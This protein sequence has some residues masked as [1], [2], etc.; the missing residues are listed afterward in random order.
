MTPYLGT[1]DIDGTVAQSN[2]I[3]VCSVQ[4]RYRHGIRFVAIVVVEIECYLV[5]RV[6][7]GTDK[8]MNYCVCS[9]AVNS[10]LSNQSRQSITGSLRGFNQDST[11]VNTYCKSELALTRDLIPI[12]SIS[13]FFFISIVF[14]EMEI[15]AHPD[16]NIAD[17]IVSRGCH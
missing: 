13:L 12:N 8:G 4:H 10:K 1:L 2:Q 6:K 5:T 16:L 3:S 9:I 14:K 7:A 15:E 11:N 17:L